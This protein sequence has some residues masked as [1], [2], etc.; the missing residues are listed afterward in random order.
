MVLRRGDLGSTL[1]QGKCSPNLHRDCHRRALRR[2]GS[3]RA[4][5]RRDPCSPLGDRGRLHERL[6]ARAAASN[7]KAEG[8]TAR[9][10][11]GASVVGPPLQL[12]VGGWKRRALYSVI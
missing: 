6:R 11:A 12:E 8:L 4:P 7:G 9:P 2:K 10:S 1:G 3:W 5:C